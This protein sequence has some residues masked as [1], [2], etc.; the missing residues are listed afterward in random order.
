M[1]ELILATFDGVPETP[2]GYVCD[3]ASR[4]GRA[5]CSIASMRQSRLIR[6]VDR[7]RVDDGSSNG[8]AGTT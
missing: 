1:G 8:Y 4:A 6:L 5:A 3:P 7:P 2:R